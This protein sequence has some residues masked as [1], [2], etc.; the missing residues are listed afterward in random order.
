MHEPWLAVRHLQAGIPMV[1]RWFAGCGR[2]IGCSSADWL[3]GC[4]IVI[5]L[6]RVCLRQQLLLQHER[7][8]S[9]HLGLKQANKKQQI[10]KIKITKN[11]PLKN[12]NLELGV[13][14]WIKFPIFLNI[15]WFSFLFW[16][17][18]ISLWLLEYLFNFWLKWELAWK[19]M[20]LSWI[21]ILVG[22]G[23]KF[24]ISG[25]Q[26]CSVSSIVIFV[27]FWHWKETSL[28]LKMGQSCP[29]KQ[30]FVFIAF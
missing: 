9:K 23:K 8:K 19:W 1:H 13:A 25:P 20:I 12:A 16:K 6:W 15:V 11:K 17:R 14:Y 10:T 26:V 22:K 30:L 5:C 28:L 3:I 2:C 4:L 29:I 21:F 27:R 24:R 7:K 18:L